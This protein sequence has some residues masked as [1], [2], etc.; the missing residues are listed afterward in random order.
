MEYGQDEL[1]VPEMTIA[2]EQRLV[3]CLTI[4]SLAR[5]THAFVEWTILTDLSLS[6]ILLPV[7]VE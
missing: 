3:A 4:F 7:K 2:G 6:V 1:D 5:Y